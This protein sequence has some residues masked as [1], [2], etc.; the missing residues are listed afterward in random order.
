MDL[1]I[2]REKVVKAAAPWSQLAPFGALRLHIN[3]EDACQL[4]QAEWDHHMS[5][6]CEAQE[7]DTTKALLAS[8]GT[9]LTEI[10]LTDLR[11]ALLRQRNFK[12]HPQDTLP[13]EIWKNLARFY[14]DFLR[15]MD[16][17]TLAVITKTRTAPTLWSLSPI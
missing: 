2:K 6:T 16:N 10:R 11:R 12:A 15:I 17:T 8:P 5:K 13:P 9:P 14:P 3:E 4:T 1:I 7:V